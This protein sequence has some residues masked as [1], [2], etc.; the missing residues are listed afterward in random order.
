MRPTEV[1]EASRQAEAVP[2]GMPC[3]ACGED[4]LV[5]ALHD[6]FLLICRCG[7]E[8]SPASIRD[9]PEFAR[10]LE[11]LRR[12]WDGRLRALQELCVDARAKGFPNVGDVVD[13]RVRML[14]AR[15]ALLREVERAL[16]PL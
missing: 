9:Y 3:P 13:R 6:T 15:V 10:G 7:R 8:V 2:E 5:S 12:I 4:L 11:S 16:R 14:R 1:F